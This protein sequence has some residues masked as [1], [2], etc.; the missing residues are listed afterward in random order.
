M[1]SEKNINQEK[2]VLKARIRELEK[3]VED[4]KRYYLK[5]VQQGKC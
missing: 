2:E 1:A 3:E 5:K 4:P